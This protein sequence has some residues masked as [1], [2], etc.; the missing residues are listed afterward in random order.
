ML[1]FFGFSLNAQETE[2]R[3]YQTGKISATESSPQ[4]DG[5]FNEPVWE[6]VEW[7]NKF[8]E[9]EPFNGQEPTEQAAFKVVY[10]DNNIYFALKA[11][12]SSPDSIET[13]LTRKD[14]MDGDMLGVGIDSY[15]DKLTS[16]NFI[17]NA[18][19]VKLDVMMT[20]DGDNEDLNWN[21]IWYVKTKVVEDGWNAEMKIPLSQL[22]F[23]SDSSLVWGLQIFRFLFRKQELSFWQHI[24]QNASG[25]VHMYGE[26]HG[27]ANIKPKRQIEIAPYGVSSF[28]TYE[29]EDG[30]PFKDGGD[31]NIKVGVDG[32]IGI[33]NNIILDFTVNPDFGQ[34]EADA[35]QVNLTAFETFYQEKRPFFIEGKNLFDFSVTGMGGGDMG[36]ENLF[37]SRRIGRRPHGYADLNSGEYDDSPR[38]T[39]ILGATKLTGKTKN[40]LSFGVLE[41]VT[42]E[43]KAE[44][45]FEG[46]RRF[47]TIEPLTN[48]FV[49]R[50]QQDFNKGVTS[51]G[52]MLTSTNRFIE[53]PNL[54]FLHT[55]AVTGGVDFTHTWKDKNYFFT[56]NNLFS[57]VK[58]SEEALLGTQ[59]SS[60]RYFQRPDAGHLEIDSS[61]TSLAGWGGRIGIGKQGGGRFNFGLMGTWK[62][63]GLE[64]NDIGF[65][66]STDEIIQVAYVGFRA[67]NPFSIFRRFSLNLA[68]WHAWDFGGTNLMTG[69]NLNFNTQFTNYWSFGTGLNASGKNLSKSMLRGGPMFLT[70]GN[71]NNYFYVDTDERK[72]LV[73]EFFAGHNWRF[74][75]SGKSQNYGFDVSYRPT[76]TLQFSVE[77]GIM[78]SNNELQYVSEEV[79]ANEARYI[80]GSIDQKVASLD[81]RINLNL[82]PD[83]SFQ[84]W[85][86]PF[87]A[88]AEYKDYKRITDSRA[89]VYTDRFHT[90]IEGVGEEIYYDANIDAYLVSE[91]G[92]VSDT[93][94]DYSFSKQD[95]N[96]KEFLSNL[97]IRWEY[98]PGS[99][100][101]VVWSQSRN[102]V[103]GDGRFVLN[104]DLR[105]MFKIH[106]HNVFLIKLSY[107]F[108]I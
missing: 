11:F 16:F 69:G 14:D 66:R 22:R 72:K 73:F 78:L 74:N 24:P 42:A 99:T 53:E 62:S 3:K 70:T 27:I 60:S 59:E 67:L 28:D 82:T 93:N 105:N 38:F 8:V 84:Y 43:E 36:S 80:F 10:D 75:N 89:D 52:A 35:S 106:P 5:L 30:N 55:S 58:G 102:G 34:V 51:L 101:Y 17:V 44:I 104:E 71:I 63:P 64:I 96:F 1:I 100:L 13:R 21:P 91:S 26:L 98:T 6:S 79:S 7:E 94:Y 4:I 9:H 103:E 40:G 97:V 47:E 61:L 68:Q 23:D 77:P 83:L 2:K 39:T 95:F 37:Y 25:F 29:E 20:N 31:F 90:F 81:F 57:Q 108:R 107:R 88:S 56:F 92:G 41:S 76:N 32:K 12:D 54:E 49:G 45:D 87:I 65:V 86:Q 33:T 46:D 18:G 19:G 50:I 15:F 48:Y 85:G